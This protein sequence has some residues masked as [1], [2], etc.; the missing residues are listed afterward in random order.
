MRR[1][2]FYLSVALLAFGIGSFIVFKFYLKSQNDLL[3]AET[4]SVSE[5]KLARSHF[6][7]RLTHNRMQ[8]NTQNAL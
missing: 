4:I 7:I 8:A 5:A 1:Y 6:K 2:T 3:D